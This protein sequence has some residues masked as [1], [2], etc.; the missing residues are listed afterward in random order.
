MRGG[1]LFM[2]HKHNL[3]LLSAKFIPGVFEFWGINLIGL[4]VKYVGHK[5]SGMVTNSCR[6]YSHTDP[7]YPNLGWQPFFRVAK[8]CQKVWW[9]CKNIWKKNKL[10]IFVEWKYHVLHA[11]LVLDRVTLFTI[12]ALRNQLRYILPVVKKGQRGGFNRA[13]VGL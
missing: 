13:N 11:F 9:V 8:T 5:R 1:V 6:L 7:W 4:S 2:W 12:I 10:L 3:L